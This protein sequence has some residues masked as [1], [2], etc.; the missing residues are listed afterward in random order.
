MSNPAVIQASIP[1]QG[2]LL[3]F[4]RS[5][6]VDNWADLEI[7][8]EVR[9]TTSAGWFKRILILAGCALVLAL[10]AFFAEAFRRKQAV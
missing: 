4:S 8:L 6:A 7:G 3:T 10:L 5:V 1:E 9:A 2:R